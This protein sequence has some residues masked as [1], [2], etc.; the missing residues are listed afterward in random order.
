MVMEYN[1][2]KHLGQ[3]EKVLP[4]CSHL[5]L[6]PFTVMGNDNIQ[7]LP[8]LGASC[9]LA[10]NMRLKFAGATCIQLAVEDKSRAVQEPV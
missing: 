6:V 8:A 5:S 1:Q 3:I 2:R 10:A 4:N 9:V 7:K